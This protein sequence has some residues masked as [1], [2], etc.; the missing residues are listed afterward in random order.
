MEDQTRDPVG[1]GIV[2]DDIE[3]EEPDEKFGKG[4]GDKPHQPETCEFA[5]GS[6]QLPFFKGPQFVSGK[7][8]QSSARPADQI[9]EFGR[10]GGVAEQQSID[11]EVGNGTAQPHCK[12]FFNLPEY[13]FL[14][15][16]SLF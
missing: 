14:I 11:H 12:V 4:I 8:E 3:M 5:S 2:P 15:I 1:E 10:K 9:G 6:G 13:L 7:A 16:F